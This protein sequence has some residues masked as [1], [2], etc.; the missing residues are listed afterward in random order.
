MLL[1]KNIL[2]VVGLRIILRKVGL[3]YLFKNF[4]MHAGIS[5]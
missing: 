2:D 4:F 1:G 3:M 5:N